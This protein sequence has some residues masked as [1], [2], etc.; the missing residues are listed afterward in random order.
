MEKVSHILKRLES[1]ILKFFTYISKLIVAFTIVVTLYNSINS[2][3]SKNLT[4]QPFNVPQS[5]FDNGITGSFVVS[6]INDDIRKFK[7][8]GWSVSA[9]NIQRFEEVN[10]QE[11]IVLFGISFNSVKSLIRNIVGVEDKSINGSLIT[12]GNILHLKLSFYNVKSV[13]ITTNVDEFNNVFEAYDQ[14][15]SK[16]AF[17]ILREVDPFILA[18]YYW[19]KNDNQTSLK[20]IKEMIE[21]KKGNLDYA[22]LLWGEILTKDKNYIQAI[23][24]FKQS[25]TI[26]SKNALAWNGWGW[27]LYK[28]NGKENE[29]ISK[30][31]KAITIN[32]NLWHAWYYWGLILVKNNQPQAAIK[33]FN[34]AIRSDS[35]KYESYNEISYVFQKLG[36]LN[37]SILYL[38]KGIENSSNPGMLYATLAEMYWLKNNKKK[39]F[40]N[41]KKSLNQGVDIYQYIEIEPYKSFAEAFPKN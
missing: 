4:I 34:K 22:Y 36:E 41:L 24:K 26:N 20:L 9:I 15:M 3:L 30:F 14:L 38:N 28:I 6:Q 18:S 21:N 25:I 33:K 7:N 23:K 16:A 1:N 2:L 31:E 12:K 40:I 32:P 37:K 39:S 8:H 19:A 17:E 11:D 29:V 13:K 27:S 10:I 5:F 35:D